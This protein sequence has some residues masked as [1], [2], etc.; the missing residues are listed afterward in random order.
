MFHYPNCREMIYI[1]KLETHAL[2]CPKCSVALSCI[3]QTLLE[4]ALERK[5]KRNIIYDDD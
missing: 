1:D 4:G 3:A 5:L 2:A